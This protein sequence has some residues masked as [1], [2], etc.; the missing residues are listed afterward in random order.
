[1]NLKFKHF[2][3]KGAGNVMINYSVGVKIAWEISSYEASNKKSSNIEIDHIMLG[4]L[5]LDKFQ[6]HIKVQSDIDRD[7]LIYEKESLYNTLNSFNLN[8]ITIRRK[9]REM[10]PDGNGLSSDNIF[11]RSEDCKKMFAEA[12]CFA[13]NYL[14]T[15]HLFLAI[16]VRE[17]SYSRNL[18]IA[19]KI[20]IDQLKSKIMFSFY[21]NN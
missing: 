3:T 6:K 20:D 21:K 13:N 15:K 11:H 16:I 5:S 2:I 17:S 7:K 19:D 12:D 9:L 14:T 10:L 4:I 1:M 8:I 18:L